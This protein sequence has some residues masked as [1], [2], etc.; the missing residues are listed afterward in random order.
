MIAAMSAGLMTMRVRR[1]PRALLSGS[2]ERARTSNM[3]AIL[4]DYNSGA[5]C[6][7]HV[8]SGEGQDVKLDISEL[9]DMPL[10]EHRPGI[11]NPSGFLYPAPPLASAPTQGTRDRG[12]GAHFLGPH[13]GL[14]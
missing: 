6:G 2:A 8:R 5:Q 14:F 4:Q 7:L 12:R 3:H 1:T 9:F 13:I 11:Q 10:L